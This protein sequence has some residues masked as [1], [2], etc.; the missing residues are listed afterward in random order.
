MV[1]LTHVHDRT[2][3]EAF[4]QSD[5]WN[6]FPQAWAWGEFQM[7]RGR[8]VV[9]LALVDEAGKWLVA[10][11]GIWY[12]KRYGTGYWLFPR[13]PVFA[14][15]LTE[16]RELFCLF[17]E[18]L[19]EVELPEKGLFFRVEPPL[20]LVEGRGMMP[21]RMQ[22]TRAL[23]PA[24]TVILDLKQTQAELLA[25]M[26]PKTRYN[27]RVAERHGVEVR[28]GSDEKDIEL[29]L[30][31]TAETAERDKFLSH[32]AEY[33]RATCE[34]L[35]PSGFARLRFAEWQGRCLAAN[36]EIAYGDTVTYLHGSSSS[37]DRQV[38]APYILHWEAIKTAQAENAAFYDLYGANPRLQS[39]VYYKSSWEGIT[40]FKRGWGGKD[41]DLMGTWDLPVNKF[42]YYLAFPK[43][44]WRGDLA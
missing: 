30:R 33:L 9:R 39:N 11:Q 21:L 3:W 42:L 27:I 13:G 38:M 2:L 34:A 20:T 28:T 26:H 40:R 44:L 37:E 24:S 22:R 8:K 29:F 31:L 5:V 4:V 32:E 35:L 17:L 23:E 14:P 10:G 18:K 36:M 16:P 1:R 7:A 25:G 41:V 12:P 19:F 43:L 6:A 15:Q